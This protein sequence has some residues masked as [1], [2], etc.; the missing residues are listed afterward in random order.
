MKKEVKID[1]KKFSLALKVA[2]VLAIIASVFLILNGVLLIA[3]KSLI[4]KMLQQYAADVAGTITESAMLWAGILWL[5]YGIIVAVVNMR[6]R[7]TLSKAWMW[8]LFVFSI[9]VLCENFKKL[10]PRGK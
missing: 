8:V 2:N 1:R 4:V 9:I 6:I 5:S 10:S 3:L 7:A